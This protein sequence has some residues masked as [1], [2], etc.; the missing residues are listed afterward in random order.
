MADYIKYRGNDY[1]IVYVDNS[2][3]T[4]LNDGSSYDN[5]LQSFPATPSLSGNSLYLIRRTNYMDISRGLCV[6]N[7]LMIAGMPA[8]DDTVLYPNLP[9]AVQTNWGSDAQPI[10]NIYLS[11]VQNLSLELGNSINQTGF[12]LFNLKLNVPAVPQTNGAIYIHG[13]GNTVYNC[14]VTVTG[15]PLSGNVTLSSM[16]N[17]ISMKLESGDGLYYDRNDVIAYGAT[18]ESPGSNIGAFGVIISDITPNI[19]V[20]TVIR[21]S[22]FRT[23]H[24]LTSTAYYRVFGLYG[25][26]TFYAGYFDN[27]RFENNK[28]SAA[29]GHYTSLHLESLANSCIVQNITSDGFSPSTQ[30]SYAS[31][32]I[33]IPT[34]AGSSYG[35]DQYK[36]NSKHTFKNI[37]IRDKSQ[38]TGIFSGLHLGTR[39]SDCIFSNITVDAPRVSNSIG[40]QGGGVYFTANYNH[41]NKFDNLNINY[42]A[43][44]VD[45][46]TTQTDC[47]ALYLDQSNAVTNA[48]CYLSNS[49]IKCSRVAINASTLDVTGV[50]ITGSAFVAGDAIHFTSVAVNPNANKFTTQQPI[51]KH[52]IDGYAQYYNPSNN[53]IKI[54]KFENASPINQNIEYNYALVAVES[55]S[56]GIAIPLITQADAYA[57]KVY[58]NNYPQNGYWLAQNYWHKM[59][60]N[61]VQYVTTD[62]ISSGYSVKIQSTVALGTTTSIQHQSLAIS[63]EPFRGDTIVCSAA[64]IG[65]HTVTVYCATKFA[66]TLSSK[67]IWVE[68]EI[69]DGSSGTQ[70]KLINTYGTNFVTVDTTTNWY[71]DSPLVKYKIEIPFN[72]E[73]QENI[74]SRIHW[75]KN[76]V[77]GSAFAYV[78]PKAI[79]R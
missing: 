58:L 67:D 45:T 79:F 12:G 61:A 40:A 54:D 1:Q 77:V 68:L 7:K 2:L 44:L 70:T 24:T 33:N 62:D 30:A 31:Y 22:I 15:Q 5:A 16:N 25:R 74:Y 69:P 43:D 34:G 23:V 52:K 18:N 29:Q 36:W 71:G 28:N 72:L 35:D 63:P 64:A 66:T 65:P 46:P 39:F 60:A 27:L 53:V 6:A 38:G 32:G 73:R 57:G 42:G 4:G 14:T 9:V 78:S 75:N 55:A 49:V 17:F 26:G 47:F 11:G 41:H 76:M 3:L 48:K 13:A 56:G 59:E 21:N 50:A 10:A 51:I 8:A 20:G 37:I 19:H